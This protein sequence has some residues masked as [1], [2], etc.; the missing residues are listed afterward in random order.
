VKSAA[1]DKIINPT[2]PRIINPAGSAKKKI[3]NP[4]GSDEK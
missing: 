3:I 2:E 1:S 4:A